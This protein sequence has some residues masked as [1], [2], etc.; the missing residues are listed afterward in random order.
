[1]EYHDDTRRYPRVFLASEFVDGDLLRLSI[2]RY[3][4][5]EKFI[6]DL[7]S[8]F[9]TKLDSLNWHNLEDTPDIYRFIVNDEVLKAGPWRR[10]RINMTNQKVFETV[11]PIGHLPLGTHTLKVEKLMVNYNLFS[12]EP[13]GIRLRK[14]WDEID[15]IKE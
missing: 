6:E 3:Q 5:D 9:K 15:F 11:I 1:M 8:N 4:G 12:N 2:A 7:K 14:Q 10:N 13:E